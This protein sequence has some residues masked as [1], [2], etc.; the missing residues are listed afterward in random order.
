MNKTEGYHLK[1]E[2]LQLLFVIMPAHYLLMEIQSMSENRTFGFQT[3]PKTEQSLVRSSLFGFRFVRFQ[4]LF[5]FKTVWNPNKFVR[6]SDT[7]L[8]LKS[9]QI[10]SKRNKFVRISDTSLLNFCLKSEQICS[11]FR[12]FNKTQAVWNPNKNVPISDSWDQKPAWLK[13]ERLDFRQLGPKAQMTEIRTF[14][15]GFLVP[16]VWNPNVWKLNTIA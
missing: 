15:S 1:I 6:I 9:E 14:G 3:T 7:N 10:Y 5:G 12:H 16:T 2:K 13:S 4:F 11:D 8:C